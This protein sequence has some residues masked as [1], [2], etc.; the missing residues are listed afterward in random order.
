MVI[1]EIVPVSITL[2]LESWVVTVKS[3][4]AADTNAGFTTLL[5]SIDREPVREEPVLSLR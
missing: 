2:L 1:A 5:S 4:N 3:S